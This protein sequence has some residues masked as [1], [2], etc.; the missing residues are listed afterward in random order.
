MVVTLKSG[1]ETVYVPLQENNKVQAELVI[2][3]QTKNQ[4][5]A[6]K[7]NKKGKSGQTNENSID[8]QERPPPAFPQKLKKSREAA[9][10]E[11]F[12]DK[13]REL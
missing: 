3:R 11:K 7:A 12:L 9:C 10:F 5:V 1:R 8:Q 13:F 6:K 4:V 2:I